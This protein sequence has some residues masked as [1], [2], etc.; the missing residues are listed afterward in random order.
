GSLLTNPREINACLRDFYKELY[1]SKVKDTEADFCNFFANLNVPQL[2]SVARDDLD[3]PFSETDLLN[4]IRAC[5]SGKTSGPD[6]FGCA[7]YKSFHDK[8]IP[9]MLRMV[10]DSMR[11]KTLPSSLY[12]ANISLL[13]K[14][15]REAVDPASYRPIAL[16]NCDL[17]IITK[18][19]ATKLGR[20]ISTILHPNQTGF[21]PGRFAFSNVRLL[22]NTVYSVHGKN[23][24][25][26]ILSL[27]AQ[28]AFDQ[29][30]WPYMLKTLEQ[31]GFGE[32]FIEWVKI[33]YLK[34][35]SSILTNSDRSQ[36]FELQRGVRQGDPLSP[37]LFDITLE[38]LVIGIRGHPGIHGIKFGNVESLVNL[39]VDDL[40]ICLSDP[41]VSVPNL[42]NYIKSF[43][44]LSG[45][46]INWD[47]CEFRPLT[48][49][50]CTF[51][52]SLPFKLANT[53][54]NYLGLKISRNPKLLLK[55]N[56]LDMVDKL[57]ANIKNWKLLPLSMIVRIN[58]IKMVALPRFLYLFQNLPIYLPLH[59]FKQLD[60][61]VLSFVWANKPPRVF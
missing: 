34:P 40:L 52:K 51:L 36:P 11:N 4:A 1:A 19:L 26:A 50:C 16:L 56:F 5:P 39:Y 2:D 27:D 61:I 38:P 43:G 7:F 24:Q 21:F 10:N 12:E 31:F 55:L 20:H 58:A 48:N 57:K 45:Y 3:A 9:L 6:G 49:M 14:G 35:V 15:G 41:V 47:K 44:K 46:A 53:H 28:K 18:V 13:L 59:F 30:E 33:I 60:S 8:I 17:K 32:H 42:L 25:A 37:L 22:L 23:A 29:I 54:I